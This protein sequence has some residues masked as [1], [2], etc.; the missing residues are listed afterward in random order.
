MLSREWGIGVLRIWFGIIILYIGYLDWNENPDVFLELFQNI[1]SSP[2]L[3]IFQ[4]LATPLLFI[5]G[6]TFLI[7]IATRPSSIVLGTILIF[8]FSDIF[9]L[10]GIIENWDKLSLILVIFSFWFIGSGSMNAKNKILRS[11]KPKKY[12]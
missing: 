8:K 6:T 12:E 10:N 9:Q 1:F 3:E 11:K 4:F 7:G 5:S 2:L